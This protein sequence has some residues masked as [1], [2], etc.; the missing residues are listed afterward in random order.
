MLP[1][2]ARTAEESRIF[3]LAVASLA[4][5]VV[6]AAAGVALAWGGVGADLLT[7]AV[8]HLVAVGFLTAVAIAMTFRLIPVLEGRAVPWPA[9]RG[10]ALWALAA[11]VPLRSAVV[12][13]GAGWPGA[14]P[15]VPLSGILLLAALV[16]V[17]ANLAAVAV[18][19]A[20][21]GRPAGP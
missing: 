20:R 7:D 6:G 1:M 12:L 13:V 18:V 21:H 10:V 8:R 19:G 9:A 15:L 5:A 4:A 2:V 11:A 14:A 17:G 3:R 16:A